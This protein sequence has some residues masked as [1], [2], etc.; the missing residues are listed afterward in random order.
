MAY[1]YRCIFAHQHHSCRFSYYKASSDDNRILTF[2]VDSVVIQD[3]H[4]CLRS[5]RRESQRFS[6][7]Y[8][9][10]RKMCHTV[11]IFC[12]IQCILDLRLNCFQMS[13]KRTE[14][15]NTVN[16]IIFVYFINHCQKFFLG[17]IFRKKDLLNFNTKGITSLGCTCLIRD[18]IRSL[19]NS[20]DT[21]LRR[22][23]FFF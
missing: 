13:R 5:T 3:L 20:D 21:K 7:K 22:N 15:Q 4:A 6:F 11:N 14:H 23:S 8:T 12:R 1:G 9:C 18:I 16:R 10:Q 2:A 19:T 17:Y